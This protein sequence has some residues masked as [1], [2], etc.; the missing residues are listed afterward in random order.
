[1]FGKWKNTEWK[2]H[3]LRLLPPPTKTPN[4]TPENM[5]FVHRWNG[6]GEERKT[7][8]PG[9]DALIAAFP[10]EGSSVDP[11][12]LLGPLFKESIIHYAL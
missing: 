5:D 7:E 12:V 10:H 6:G 4:L 2:K 8:D 1:M 3:Y 9:E 11:K